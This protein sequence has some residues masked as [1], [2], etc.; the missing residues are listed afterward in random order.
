[1]H[2][3]PDWQRA[4]GR[5]WRGPGTRPSFSYS[6]G[7]TGSVGELPNTLRLSDPRCH[8]HVG[9]VAKVESFFAIRPRRYVSPETIVTALRS[10]SREPM[11]S[12]SASSAVV[13]GTERVLTQGDLRLTFYQGV[14]VRVVFG[15]EMGQPPG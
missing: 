11:T 14:P 7:R 9:P 5:G 6:L 8:R 12:A 2:V 4:A 13:T 1:M 3:R 10:S 15:M